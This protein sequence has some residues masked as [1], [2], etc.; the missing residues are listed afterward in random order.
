MLGKGLIKPSVSP[1]GAPILFVRKN[2]GTLTLCIDYSEINKFT[3]RHRYPLPHIDDFFDQLK[4]AT[5][6]SSYQMLN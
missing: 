6:K 5:T 4:G 3:I 2:D 1:W